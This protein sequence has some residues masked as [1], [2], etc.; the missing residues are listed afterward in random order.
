M[1]RQDTPYKIDP[2]LPFQKGN[3]KFLPKRSYN[4]SMEYSINN[5]KCIN[6]VRESMEGITVTLLCHCGKVTKTML[7]YFKVGGK[8]SCGCLSKKK[9]KKK[10][11]K[12]GS[13]PSSS[14]YYNFEK[15]EGTSPLV[16]YKDLVI[17]GEICEEWRDYEVFLKWYEKSYKS[18]KYI[19]TCSKPP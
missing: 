8:T 19:S 9:K 14:K 18:P 2:T 6:M 1:K 11:K 15:Y 3:I 16:K 13:I 10:K 5:M 7:P 12:T 4:V 17:R